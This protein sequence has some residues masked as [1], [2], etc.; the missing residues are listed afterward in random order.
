MEEVFDESFALNLENILGQSK[1]HLTEI[2]NAYI[3]IIMFLELNAGLPRG[4]IAILFIVL[5]FALYGIIGVVN[6][7]RNSTS[8]TSPA[9]RCRPSSTAWRPAPT[10]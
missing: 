5:S 6:F 1:W 4:L 9:G 2:R 10:G 7:T 3:G 8:T